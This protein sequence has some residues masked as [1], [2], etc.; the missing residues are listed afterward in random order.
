M[1]K[2]QL[3]LLIAA[4]YIVSQG[5]RVSQSAPVVGAYYY[6][7]S[8]SFAGGHN[9]NTTLREHLNPQQ[10]PAAGYYDSRTKATIE[11]HIDQSHL[12]NISFWATSWWGP[13]SAEDTTTRTKILTDPRASEL[14][15]AIHYE[16]TGR[17]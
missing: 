1:T 14:K 9:W 7:W 11:A 6:P 10:P 5:T 16:S 4:A 8:G 3:V 12:G 17:L 13:T 15:Y 2:R